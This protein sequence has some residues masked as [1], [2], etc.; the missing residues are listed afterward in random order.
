MTL[1]WQEEQDEQDGDPRR[2]PRHPW[3][4]TSDGFGLFDTPCSACEAEMEESYEPA[5]R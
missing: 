4:Q 2:C 3:I 1:S 5:R